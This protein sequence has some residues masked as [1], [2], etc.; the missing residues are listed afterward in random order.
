MKAH[1][2]LHLPLNAELLPTLGFLGVLFI[3]VAFGYFAPESQD[4]LAAVVLLVGAFVASVVS[5]GVPSTRL[6]GLSLGLFY[7]GH[8]FALPLF[9]PNALVTSAAGILFRLL[10]AAGSYLCLMLAIHEGVQ[11]V[12]PDSGLP[13]EGPIPLKPSRV[14]VAGSISIT[15]IVIISIII[16]EKLMIIAPD[17]L[18]LMTVAIVLVGALSVVTTALSALLR[19][20]RTPYWQSGLAFL[21]SGSIAEITVST[22]PFFLSSSSSTLV[23]L[24]YLTGGYFILL[25]SRQCTLP[26]KSKSRASFNRVDSIREALASCPQ[27][28]KLEQQ[29]FPPVE[30]C[31][32]ADALTLELLLLSLASNTSFLDSLLGSVKNRF[33]Y[34]TLELYEWLPDSE[35]LVK[36]WPIREQ[37]LIS[38][39]LADAMRQQIERLHEPQILFRGSGFEVTPELATTATAPYGIS[40]LGMMSRK[41]ATRSDYLIA[42]KDKL[43]LAAQESTVLQAISRMLPNLYRMSRRTQGLESLIAKLPAILSG[44]LD[45]W[46]VDDPGLLLRT[47]SDS[48]RQ[49]LGDR[50]MVL[51]LRRSDSRPDPDSYDP[52]LS[53]RQNK[54]SLDLVDG[55]LFSLSLDELS[56]HGLLRL[57]F[58]LF[59]ARS[60]PQPLQP[61]IECLQWQG[62]LLVLFGVNDNPTGVLCCE[63]AESELDTWHILAVMLLRSLGTQVVN[64]L[65]VKLWVKDEELEYAW[66][67][68]RKAFNAAWL[69]RQKAIEKNL[70]EKF[71]LMRRFGLT[72]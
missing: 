18:R 48:V 51:F 24:F 13:P 49:M 5:I 70:N 39:E 9:R 37:G 46:Q 65:R 8:A 56:Q 20:S 16:R 43:T 52:A 55:V 63:A 50:E 34:R 31:D 66:L 23:G 19:T 61:C 4:A 21:I 26:L 44:Y 12:R 15:V 53:F 11:Q 58:H 30:S 47:F 14:M 40:V 17:A 7:L 42:G 54:F 72:L 33:N 29:D 38:D 10:A 69:D 32:E 3:F 59:T 62:I 2:Q 41:T 71:D 35:T 68:K 64:L 1:K 67:Q 22:V 28:T 27:L 25:D 36:T 45:H 6:V 57:P 60:V